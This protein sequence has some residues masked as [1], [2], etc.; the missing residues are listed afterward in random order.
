MKL[1]TK[2][3]LATLT[4][5][6]MVGTATSAETI[7]FQDNFDGGTADLN[8]AS[9]DLGGG[10]WVATPIFD[11]NGDVNITD[12]P[13]GTNSNFGAGSATL[14]FTPVDGLIYTADAS[15]ALSTG[16]GGDWVGFGFGNGQSTIQ[17]ASNRFLGATTEGRAWMY[18]RENTN[19]PRAAL[20]NI[21][22]QTAWTGFTQSP[23]V[24]DMRI[25]LDTTG[26]TG[27][28][29]ATW[30]AKL[31]ESATYTEI[32]TTAGLADEDINSIG[33][34]IAG[35]TVT[36]DITNFSLTSEVPEPSS[37][38]L[39]GLGGLLIARRRRA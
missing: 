39:L 19:N 36:A 38:A 8:G 22:D 18:F 21:D 37:L 25:V 30:F 5:G 31:P 23:S 35:D 10:T 14:A 32:R 17:N 6:L 26:G 27:N 12:V 11:Q 13:T 1:H 15:V 34:V 7:I 4:L 3:L 2:T 33:F 20:T 9:T 29:T 24:A 28:W 16:G